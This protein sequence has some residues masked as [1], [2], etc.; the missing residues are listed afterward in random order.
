MQQFSRWE[1]HGIYWGFMWASKNAVE[2]LYRF[3]SNLGIDCWHYIPEELD[4]YNWGDI[5]ND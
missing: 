4:R 5:Y 3:Y 2:P 1:N